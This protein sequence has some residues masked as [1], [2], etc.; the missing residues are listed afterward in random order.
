MFNLNRFSR[1]CCLIVLGAFITLNSVL[2]AQPESAPSADSTATATNTENYRLLAKLPSN[3]ARTVLNGRQGR[4]LFQT[5]QAGMEWQL[6]TFSSQDELEQTKAE[7]DLAGIQ[8]EPDYR[9]SIN[10]TPNDTYYDQQ[11][12][13]HNIGQ[14]GGTPDADIDAPEAWDI[15]TGSSEIIVAVIDSGI[16]YN[17]PDLKA[18]MWINPGENPNNNIDDDGNGYKDDIYGANFITLPPLVNPGDPL[19]DNGHG[20]HVAGIIGAVSNNAEGVA[21]VNHKVSLMALKFL[22]SD[23]DGWISDAAKAIKYAV[24]KQADVINASWGDNSF[25]QCLQDAIALANGAGILFVAAAGNTLSDNDMI[26]VYPASYDVPNVLTVA[27]TDRNDELGVQAVEDIFGNIIITGGSNFGEVSVDLGAPGKAILSTLPVPPLSVPPLPLVEPLPNGPYNILDGTSM[28]APHVAGVAALLLAQ[29]P[30]LTPQQLKSTLMFSGDPKA[31]LANKTVSGRRLNAYAALNAINDSPRLIISD[32]EVV[33]AA[34]AQLRFTVTMLGVANQEVTVDYSTMDD[35]ATAD[36]DYQARNGTLTFA[37]GEAIKE[38]EVPVIAD[39]SQ[40]AEEKFSLMLRNVSNNAEIQDGKAEGIIIDNSGPMPS[41]SIAN[42]QVSEGGIASVYVSLSGPTK[43]PVTVHVK[44]VDDTAMG[45]L[46]NDPALR[47]SDYISVNEPLTF[48]PDGD[49][50]IPIRISTLHDDKQ[51]SPEMFKV[52]LTNPVNATLANT[53]AIVTINNNNTQPSLSF[54]ITNILVLEGE[55]AIMDLS[56]SAPSALP[57][58]VNYA[59]QNDSAEAGSD[60]IAQTHQLGFLPG[61]TEFLIAV[62]TVDDMMVENHELFKGKLTGA[63]NATINNTG[64]EVDVTIIDNDVGPALIITNVNVDEGKTAKVTVRLSDPSQSSASMTLT[65]AD[66][67]ALAGSDYTANS[68]ELTFIPGQIERSLNIS[69]IDDTLDE[70]LE[71]FKV[72]ITNLTN[73][74]SVVDPAVEVTINDN[75]D[76]PK[77]SVLDATVTEGDTANVIVRLDNPS[78]KEIILNLEI[79]NGSAVAGEDFPKINSTELTISPGQTQSTLTIETENDMLDENDEFFEVKLTSA[80]NATLDD[81]EATVTIQDN[82]P[83]PSLVLSVSNT[84]SVTEG[85]TAIIEAKLSNPSARQIIVNYAT[86][87]GT[88]VAPGDYIAVSGQLI[89]EPGETRLTVPV[90]TVDDDLDEG[91]EEFKFTA[92]IDDPDNSDNV[93]LNDTEVTIT[94]EDNDDDDEPPFS[95]F[96]IITDDTVTPRPNGL[97]LSD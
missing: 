30:N 22:D 38:I 71:T 3:Q 9:L 97:F 6:L 23:G 68:S 79:I 29:N 58:S 42:T 89:F 43:L 94:I 36:S 92:T 49:L 4:F 26:P 91:T 84:G 50:S 47:D 72:D 69:T 7:L 48:I 2:H 44:T 32:A 96:F 11:W 15:T 67:T 12:G 24:D 13:L 41:L 14:D 60:Y 85:D 57:I 74:V 20:T 28:A 61:Q 39:Q 31:D 87:D 59:T 19:D 51:E 83:T 35:S 86:E 66:G 54:I 93:I 76:P 1:T 46:I 27:Y 64:N 88:A 56:L 21:G 78:A 53:Q 18:N 34:D 70:D 82:D 55:N 17:H 77:V 5:N 37:V 52:T 40:E 95:P 25:S 33:E 73:A 75:D 63:Q 80:E 8:H 16:D 62:R 10:L 81:A 90:K 65:T 45:A